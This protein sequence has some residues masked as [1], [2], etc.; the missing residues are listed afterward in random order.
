MIG[1]FP[2]PYADELLY[3]ACA[4]FSK[5]VSYP[6]RQKVMRELFGS[7][8][9]S[10]IVDFPTRLESLLATF[11][12]HN[13]TTDGLISKNTLFPFYEPFISIERAEQVRGEMKFSSENHIR[14]RLAVNVPQAKSPEYLRFCPLCVE[15][16]RRTCGETFWHRI[17]QLAGI[18]VCA[19]HNCFLQ[20]SVVRW[21]RE[22]AA[23]F[24]C[25][26]E[27][28]NMQPPRYLCDNDSEHKLF[29][30]LARNAEWLLTRES[31]CLEE[32]ALR[33]RY[34]NLL[35]ERGYAYY[36]GRTRNNK[37]FDGF[38]GHFTP[39]ILETL[40]CVVQSAQTGWLAKFSDKQKANV[41]HHPIRHLLVMNFLNLTAEEFF[42]AFVEY[43]PFGDG[44]YPCLNN[45]SD[46]HGQLSIPHCEIFDNISKDKNKSGRPL[47]VFTC[48]CGFTYQR[49]GPDKSEKE[50]LT[51][52]LVRE[53]GKVWE[54]RLE[55]LWMDLSISAAQIARILKVSD[56]LVVRHAIRL[57]LPMNKPNSRSVEGYSRYRNPN[58]SFSDLT[59]QYRRGWLK[60][61]KDN[62]KLTRQKLMN[63]ANFLYLWLRRNDSKWFE[64]HLPEAQKLP[65]VT[66]HIDWRSIDEELSVDVER[67]CQEILVRPILFKEFVLPR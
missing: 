35:L 21:E 30:Y 40:G 18:L 51:Y 9:F 34:Y 43:K 10:A 41:I 28:L 57:N 46:H 59:A 2:T 23:G 38:N 60:V 11:P 22:S 64:K 16:D 39:R 7:K 25:A 50:R 17:H 1:F 66:E 5:R 56:L 65:R 14:M 15:E 67:T 3:S 62:P 6:N 44:P 61:V 29:L 49:V 32:G 36:N 54:N 47:G 58:K 52:S 53:Y 27:S 19:K 24:H 20:N 12:P 37:L 63:T 4:R 31:L 33:A 42:T 13:Y 26:E 55:Q 8:A 45:A 48:G